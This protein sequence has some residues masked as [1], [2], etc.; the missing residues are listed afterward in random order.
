MKGL[1][2]GAY[3]ISTLCTLNLDAVCVA[4]VH[5]ECQQCKRTCFLYISAV[6]GLDLPF[7]F[8]F[9]YNADN[10]YLKFFFF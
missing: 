9:P 10:T 1:G 5:S 4:L 3:M 6:S 2:G 7:F 8:F